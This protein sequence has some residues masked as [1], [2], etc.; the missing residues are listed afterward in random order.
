M[1][2]MKMIQLT[3]RKRKDVIGYDSELDKMLI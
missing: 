1:M 3:V 2:R